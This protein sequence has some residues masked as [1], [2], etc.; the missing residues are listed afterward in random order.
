MDD[1]TY[2][3]I[4]EKHK[5][6]YRKD[7]NTPYIKHPVNV[8]ACVAKVTKDEDLFKAALLHDVV[9]DTDTSID[10]IRGRFGSEIASIVEEL[11]KDKQ[12]REA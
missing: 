5:G 4:R 12:E 10:E 9:E 7:G 1:S 8:A 2:D 11:T 6:Q 3:Y